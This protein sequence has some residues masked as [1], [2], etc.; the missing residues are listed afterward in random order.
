MISW[1]QFP[2]ISSDRLP[3]FDGED[4]LLAQ[5]TDWA[6][7]HE[8]DFQ[9]YFVLVAFFDH[10]DRSFYHRL[11]GPAERIPCP[12]FEECFWSEINLPDRAG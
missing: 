2:E 4:F 12:D 6:C 1:R 7:Q 3:P 5:R 11:D 8:P 10:A 9:A